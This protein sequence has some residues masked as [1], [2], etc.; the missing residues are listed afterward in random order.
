MYEYLE[1]V[2][3]FFFLIC[4][5]SSQLIKKN[6]TEFPLRICILYNC[7]AYYLSHISSK[8]RNS[9]NGLLVSDPDKMNKNIYGRLGHFIVQQKL[10]EHCKSTIIKNF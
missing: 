7:H 5:G 2:F 3:D 10:T 1:R 9:E 6:L 8:I 4:Q